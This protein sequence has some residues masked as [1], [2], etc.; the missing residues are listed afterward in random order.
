MGLPI[1]LL[2]WLVVGLVVAGVGAVVLISIAR[3]LTRRVT[4]GRRR[5]VVAAGLLPFICLGWEGCVFVV[6]AIVNEGFL[7]R[8]LG[9]GDTWHAPLPNGYQV[10][11]IDRNG[12]RMGVQ[13]EDTAL[14]ERDR[15]TRCRPRST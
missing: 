4:A 7:R 6:Q 3:V 10:M 12:S 1:V 13:P 9:L 11:M 15:K 2:M 5:I 14:G 8:D